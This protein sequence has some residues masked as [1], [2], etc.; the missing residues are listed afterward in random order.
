M[1][2]VQYILDN[3]GVDEV[4]TVKEYRA[5]ANK[6]KLKQCVYGLTVDGV[7]IVAG[8]G[9]RNRAEVALVAKGQKPVGHNNSF[10]VAANIALA[11]EDK[12]KRAVKLFDS[13]PEVANLEKQMHAAIKWHDQVSRDKRSME[14]AYRFFKHFNLSTRAGDILEQ[15]CRSNHEVFNDIRDARKHGQVHQFAVMELEEAFGFAF[16]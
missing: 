2:S 1:N 7:S 9:G 8:S 5:L 10:L 12:I 11:P 14:L 3:I 15:Y 13:K 4:S 6:T 16:T